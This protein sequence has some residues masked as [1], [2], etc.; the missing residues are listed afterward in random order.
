MLESL[1]PQPADPLLGVT[2]AFRADP[3]PD[4]VDLGVGV[5]RDEAGITPIM[6]AVS[7]AA[8]RLLQIEDTKVYVGAAGNR[9]WAAPLVEHTVRID[10]AVR[11]DGRI[12]TL[13]T[14]GG[15]GALRLAAELLFA[16][17]ATDIVVST[18][19]WANHVPLLSSARLQLANYP[20]YSASSGK[21]DVAAVLDSLA[22]LKPGTVVLLQ[23]SCH[24][25]TGADLDASAW[26][27]IAQLLGKRGLL[28]LVDIAY[29][30]LGRGLQSDVEPVRR[31][32]EQLPEVLVAVSCS[33][34]FGLYRE[35][36]G[37]VMCVAANPTQA[38]TVMSHLQVLARRMYSM[39]PNYGA[40]LVADIWYEAQLRAEWL[41]E[42]EAMRLRVT[43]LRRALAAALRRAAGTRFDFIEQQAGMFSLL[44]LGSAAVGKLRTE[45][46]V[47]LAPDSRMNVAGLRSSDIDR[48][49]SAI[50]RVC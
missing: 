21:P 20:Y 26:S 24:N 38:Q 34:N 28:P 39:P 33:K 45:H 29:Q 40:A 37:A 6:G 13:Q 7:K 2:T 12:V 9:P 25:P 49:A 36:V 42:L 10:H 14:P 22:T 27:Q 17:G 1:R 32:A 15:C 30:G 31:L 19:T 4:K 41:A 43:T 46:H 48:V 18:P 3:S 8:A 5:Y 47:Y 16:S 44:G 50:A 35:R 23:A 11:R